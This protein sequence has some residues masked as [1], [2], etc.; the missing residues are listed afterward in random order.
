MNRRVDAVNAAGTG[1]KAAG[2]YEVQI[3]ADQTLTFR[4]RLSQRMPSSRRM[5]F[6][7]AFDQLFAQ[8]LREADEFYAAITPCP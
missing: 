7:S 2:H 6:G 8:R 5:A 1:T 4:L 3:P